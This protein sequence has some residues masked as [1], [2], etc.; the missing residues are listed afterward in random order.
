MELEHFK[1]LLFKKDEKG[2]TIEIN[3][4]PKR[5]KFA[6]GSGGQ[7]HVHLRSLHGC[8]H[9]GAPLA[10]TRNESVVRGTCPPCRERDRVA[11]L[12]VG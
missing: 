5:E 9:C 6:Y 12:S 1:S 8:Y 4:I 10:S 11:G 3:I 2:N 7:R